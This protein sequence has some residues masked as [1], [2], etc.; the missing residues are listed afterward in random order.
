MLI[1]VGLNEEERKPCIAWLTFLTFKKKKENPKLQVSKP[2]EDI[3]SQCYIFCNQHKFCSHVNAGDDSRDKDNDNDSDNNNHGNNNDSGGND[4]SNGAR[5]NDD[6]AGSKDKE[7]TEGEMRTLTSVMDAENGTTHQKEK[8]IKAAYHVKAAKSE[9]QLFNIK[10]ANGKW[11]VKNNVP[12]YS[13]N[14]VPH[15]SKDIAL[16]LIIAN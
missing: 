7:M 9:R 4:C 12:H 2:A 5:D 16:L 6:T 3:C 11:D 10:I 14:N 8:M 15:Y 1:P 13:K